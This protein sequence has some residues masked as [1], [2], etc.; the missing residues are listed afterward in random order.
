M[1]SFP[2]PYTIIGGGFGLY[3]YLPAILEDPNA[4]VVLPEEYRQK[5]ESRPDIAAYSARIEWLPSID[6]ALG[7]ASFV[8]VAVPPSSQEQVIQRTLSYPDIQALFL[9]KPL[10]PEPGRSAELLESVIRAKKRIRVGY[11]FFFTT[12][13]RQLKASLREPA[14]ELRISWLFTSHHVRFNQDTWKK[15]HLIGGG[16]LRFFGIHLVAVLASLGYDSASTRILNGRASGQPT[17]WEAEFSGFGLPPCEVIVS[18]VSDR[19]EFGVQVL[20]PGGRAAM[21]FFSESPF[22]EPHLDSTP[23]YRIAILRQLLESLYER[24]E[25]YLSIYRATNSLW[26]MAEFALHELP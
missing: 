21:D 18:S 10:A 16:V 17:L 19:I 23:D 2:G 26:K 11:T 3:G 8:I 13:Y 1:S 14:A 25:E 7:A 5:I 22:G 24:D 12:W 6:A 9:E 4:S 20:R 15:H